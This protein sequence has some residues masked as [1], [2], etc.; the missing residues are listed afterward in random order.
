[1]DYRKEKN[2]L[3]AFDGDKVKGQYDWKSGIFYGVRGAP[4]K[5]IPT[6]FKGSIYDS[7]IAS[8]KWIISHTTDETLARALDKWERLASVGLYT[9]DHELLTSNYELAPLKKGLVDYIKN[10]FNCVYKSFYVELYNVTVN[11]PEYNLLQ[12]VYKNYINSH[13][14]CNQ[15]PELPTEWLVKAL[16]RIQNEDYRYID[17]CCNSMR[18]IEQYYKYSMNMTNDAPITKNFIITIAHTFHL[19]ENWKKEH[20]ADSI[21]MHNDIPQLYYENDTYIVRPLLTPADF[22]KEASAQQ[23]CVERLYM[24]RVADGYTHVVVVRRKDDPDTSLVTC[25]INNNW[26]VKQYYAK[27]NRRPDTPEMTFLIELR[28]YLSS[29]SK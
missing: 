22:H 13:L 18:I 19:Y 11:C 23:N 24:E 26:E 4:I 15:F 27:Y 12:D 14:F 8:H 29:L 16:F 20:M 21:R 7:I 6:A 10:N 3:I 9:V 2:L 17:D 1:M 25:E 28:Q 5:T